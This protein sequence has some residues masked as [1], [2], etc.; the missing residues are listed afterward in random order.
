[1]QEEKH[2]AGDTSSTLR[3]AGGAGQRESR[4]LLWS[5]AGS[6]STGTS[7]FF[8]TADEWKRCCL[9][10]G[11]G[12]T[13]IVSIVA[14]RA[15]APLESDAK[16]ALSSSLLGVFE[17]LEEDFFA[18]TSPD[19]AAAPLVDSDGSSIGVHCLRGVLLDAA[20]A[21]VADITIS[22]HCDV[23]RRKDSFAGVPFRPLSEEP[24]D[25]S[26]SK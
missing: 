17:A 12:Q 4:C 25:A 23:A 1:M 19:A 24:D 5:A 22:F 15:A 10:A 6:L 13:V 21:R 16:S 7:I 2:D 26:E 9:E 11:T 14:E 8:S 18:A 3:E 20:Y